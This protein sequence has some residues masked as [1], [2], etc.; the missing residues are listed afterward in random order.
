MPPAAWIGVDHAV[1]GRG[2]GAVA[3]VDA[4]ALERHAQGF[5][6]PWR[7]H[8]GEGL[9]ILEQHAHRTDR[10]RGRRLDEPGDGGKHLG[11]RGVARHLLE[12][13]VLGGGHALA[14]LAFGDVGD[15]AAHQVAIAA[16]QV[17]QAHFADDLA[18]RGITVRPLEHGCVA[19]ERLLN[20]GARALLGSTAVGLLRRT[21][22]HRPHLQQ[23]LAIEAKE[24][25]RIVVRVHEATGVDVQ[26]HD[27]LGGVIDQQ[28]I[29]RGALAHGLLGL[30]PLGDIAQAQDEHLAP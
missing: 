19:L 29:A 14:A 1:H 15:A 25:L 21:Q 22:G 9:A 17:H 16:R 10:S 11:E 23:P 27:R 12:H 28:A 8:V 13:L 6:K 5:R 24:L 7:D 30:A 20:I 3:D 18:A 2:T 26:D 4:R